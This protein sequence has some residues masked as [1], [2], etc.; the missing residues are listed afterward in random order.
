[1]TI[2][3]KSWLRQWSQPHKVSSSILFELQRCIQ[4]VSKIDKWMIDYLKLKVY[5]ISLAQLEVTLKIVPRLTDFVDSLVRLS[6]EASQTYVSPHLAF[7]VSTNDS[8]FLQ[9]NNYTP[10]VLI[11][12]RSSG[13]EQSL[14]E[15]HTLHG[16]VAFIN[17]SRCQTTTL[18]HLIH[19][20]NQL[21]SAMKCYT[22]IFFY[23]M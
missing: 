16:N 13:K 9:N 22:N 18:S 23:R 10:Y 19:Q 6:Y 8:S 3:L 12:S 20:I 15:D 2:L 17:K 14:W 21:V 4:T 7:Q 11:V 5:M 1:M